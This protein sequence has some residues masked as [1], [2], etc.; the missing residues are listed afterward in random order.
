MDDGS[1][2]ICVHYYYRRWFFKGKQRFDEFDYNRIMGRYIYIYSNEIIIIIIIEYRTIDFFLQRRI[3]SILI[4]R[5]SLSPSIR[6]YIYIFYLSLLSLPLPISL[7]RVSPS[8][9]VLESSAN[10]A[11]IYTAHSTMR[12]RLLSRRI[13]ACRDDCY[14]DIFFSHGS[15]IKLYCVKRNE[16]GSIYPRKIGKRKGKGREI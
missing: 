14:R 7:Y 10:R 9:A 11:T 15:P 6:I 1:S 3:F 5:W 12:A 16:E 4:K 2:I 8:R 13:K